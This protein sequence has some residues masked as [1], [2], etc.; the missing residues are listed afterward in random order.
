MRADIEAPGQPTAAA[1][2]QR[3]A[4]LVYDQVSRLIARGEFPR[5][6]KLPSEGELSRRFGVSR[7]VVRDALARLKSEG[8]IRSQQ[9]S[10]TIVVRGE[11]PGNG[12]FPIRSVADL[13]RSYEFRITVETATAA[14]AAMHRTAETLAAIERTLAA[15]EEALA[16]HAPHLLGDLNFAF[17]RAIAGATSNPFFITTLEMIPNFIGR[18]SLGAATFGDAQAE[19]RAQRVHAEHLSILEAI[20]DREP[21]RARTEM[22]RHI[23][24]A[25]DVVLERQELTLMPGLAR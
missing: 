11:L 7:P 13:L 14:L 1:P 4:D 16:S 19:E 20:R 21:M 23:A 3:L 2:H 25:R 15:A 5:G 22:E 10:G 24:N 6:C 17:H 18:E 8:A 12:R 9:G